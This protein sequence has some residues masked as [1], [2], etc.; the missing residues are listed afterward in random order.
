[1]AERLLETCCPYR[2][3]HIAE[4]YRADDTEHIGEH[5]IQSRAH[6]TLYRAHCILQTTEQY[7]AQQCTLQSTTAYVYLQSRAHHRAAQSTG[8]SIPEKH[9]RAHCC[10]YIGGCTVH[11]AAQCPYIG[12]FPPFKEPTR[13]RLFCL[14]NSA[15]FRLEKE[16]HLKKH[17]APRKIAKK[18]FGL[19]FRERH[20]FP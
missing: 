19:L 10:P 18:S 8:R 11:I 16:I 15:H 13:E 12:G 6:C 1:M 4:Q 2:A 14:C 9:R 5:T 17:F 20:T 7:R 3:E